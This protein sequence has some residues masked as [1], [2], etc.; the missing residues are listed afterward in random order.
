M[1]IFEQIKKSQLEDILHKAEV[2]GDDET[3]QKAFIAIIE[4]GGKKAVVG[5]IREWKGGKFR[6]TASGWEPVTE[7][8]DEKKKEVTEKT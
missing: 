1:D 8:G 4:K 3:I 5:E 2:L 6:R 7:G